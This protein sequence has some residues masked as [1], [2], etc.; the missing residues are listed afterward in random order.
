MPKNYCSG[1]SKYTVC[2]EKPIFLKGRVFNT[3]EMG[4]PVILESPDAIHLQRKSISSDIKSENL[5]QRK[6]W[7]RF[8]SCQNKMKIKWIEKQSLWKPPDFNDEKEIHWINYKALHA[9]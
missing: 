1:A 3:I 9:Y 4:C 6:S 8:M 7:Y 5:Y 2:A